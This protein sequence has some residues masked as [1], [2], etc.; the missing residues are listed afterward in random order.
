V[1]LVSVVVIIYVCV[2]KSFFFLFECSR[3]TTN[4]KCNLGS[5][6]FRDAEKLNVCSHIVTKRVKV[7]HATKQVV[8]FFLV[9]ICVW[10]P[11]AY[12]LM[13]SHCILQKREGFWSLQHAV[14]T[15]WL[16]SFYRQEH[17]SAAK[18]CGNRFRLTNCLMRSRILSR[19]AHSIQ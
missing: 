10:R 5:R 11:C 18:I 12:D 2:L 14:E 3:L 6:R 8:I 7:C 19:P 15:R 1:P 13:S 4:L 9:Y 17:S 16:G